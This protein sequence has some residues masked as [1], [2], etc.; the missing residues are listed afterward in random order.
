MAPAVLSLISGRPING[1]MLT[2]L[3]LAQYPAIIDVRAMNAEMVLKD[4]M[5]SATRMDAI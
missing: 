2:Q 5:G 4:K 1:R 3:I